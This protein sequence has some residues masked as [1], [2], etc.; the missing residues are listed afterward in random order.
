MATTAAN[1][2]TIRD[3]SSLLLSSGWTAC[4]DL[5][6]VS[7]AGLA[8]WPA[9]A[10]FQE[11]GSS[12]WLVVPLSAILGVGMT[13]KVKSEQEIADERAA[14]DAQA[15]ALFRHQTYAPDRETYEA[16]GERA[17][18]LCKCGKDLKN[19]GHIVHYVAHEDALRCQ[20]RSLQG[21]SGLAVRYG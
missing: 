4:R 1:V 10:R 9:A 18:W 21:C 5:E 7:V 11:P 3:A 2:L 15:L 20:Q 12:R 13:H 8:T 19:G 16:A 6:L 14:I 17:G